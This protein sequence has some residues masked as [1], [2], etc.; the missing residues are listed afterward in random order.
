[1]HNIII[2]NYLIMFWVFIISKEQIIIKIIKTIYIIIFNFIDCKYI[3]YFL[4]V[5][6]KKKNVYIFH[7]LFF[8][9]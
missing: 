7:S 3:L 1:M 8:D 6:I 2:N 9:L 5:F 4:I